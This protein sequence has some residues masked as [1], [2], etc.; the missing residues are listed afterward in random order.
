MGELIVAG[1]ALKPKLPGERSPKTR[2]AQLRGID[3]SESEA[4]ALFKRHPGTG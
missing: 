2:F 4:E 1:L 3:V